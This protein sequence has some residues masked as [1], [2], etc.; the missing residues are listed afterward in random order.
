M[1]ECLKWVE[2][3][4]ETYQPVEGFSDKIKPERVEG[5][6]KILDVI[7]K[8]VGDVREKGFLDIGC[9]FGYFALELAKMGA[10]TVG[11]EHD[12]RRTDVARYFADKHNLNAIFVTGDAVE[13]INETKPTADYI[14]LLN[15]IHHLF[16]QNE[17]ET[18]KMFNHLIDNSKG[19]FIMM[20]NQLKTWKLCD[21]RID[22]PESVISKSHATN[23]IDYGVVHGRNIYFFYKVTG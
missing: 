3:L 12:K 6:K 14:I 21:K 20:R 1:S 22:I 4:N 11:Y 16:L 13:I 18:W 7:V 15:T 19:I 23:Y 2:R 17:G 9:N 5:F 8:H 10:Y